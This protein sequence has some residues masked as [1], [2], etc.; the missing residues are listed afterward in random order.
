[1]NVKELVNEPNCEL[2]NA[3]YAPKYK[4][5][6]TK[7]ILRSATFVVGV[8]IFLFSGRWE[9]GY[10]VINSDSNLAY[11]AY[12]IMA[13]PYLLLAWKILFKGARAVL[14]DFSFSYTETTYSDGSKTSTYSENFLAMLLSKLFYILLRAFI[15]VVAIFFFILLTPI[16]VI[17]FILMMK[18]LKRKYQQELNE[19]VEAES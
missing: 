6:L 16:Q 5:L 7:L 15:A 3:E 8:V 14:S 11:V 1:M 12:G 17:Y 19:G 2:W 13:I 9:G 10:L 4:T 18:R